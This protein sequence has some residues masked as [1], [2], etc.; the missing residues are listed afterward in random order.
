MK[1]IFLKDVKGVGRKYEEKNVADGYAINSLIPKKLAVPATGSAAGQI[2]SLKENDAKHKEAELQ[3]LR[4]HIQNLSGIELVVETKANEKNH[5]FAALTK[6][7]IS[8]LLLKE[9]GIEIEANCIKTD[10]IKELGTF[11]IPVRVE[12]EKETHF[13]L[14]VRTK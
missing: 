5:L 14:I 9:K 8:E 6:E 13:T 1:V 4:G 10:P 7:K 2:K 3:K 12:N 11:T